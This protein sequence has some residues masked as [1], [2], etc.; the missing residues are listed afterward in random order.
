[1]RGPRAPSPLRPHV[2][3]GRGGPGIGDRHRAV[4][5]GARVEDVS[6]RSV[7][8]PDDR[9][10]PLPERRLL[11]RGRGLRRSAVPMADG[12]GPFFGK[13]RHPFLLEA[14]T[15][16]SVGALGG[17]APSILEANRRLRDALRARGY[18]V[19]CREIPGGRHTVETWGSRFPDALADLARRA[20]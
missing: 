2:V 7:G 4:V 19:D 13:E 20:S 12:P 17:A 11:A 1:R 3:E 5:V 15:G 8:D 10:S 9:I 14:G 16:E 6:A 18:S